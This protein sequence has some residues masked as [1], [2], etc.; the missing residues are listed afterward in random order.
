LV[1]AAFQVVVWFCSFVGFD[2]RYPLS[3]L[4]EGWSRKIQRKSSALER[5]PPAVP[6]NPTRPEALCLRARQGL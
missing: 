5:I 6:S 2:P 1:F 4:V 3:I